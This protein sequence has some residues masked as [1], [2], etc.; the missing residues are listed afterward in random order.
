[1][2]VKFAGLDKLEMRCFIRFGI[3]SRET[4]VVKVFGGLSLQFC[5]LDTTRRS[6]TQIGD[7]I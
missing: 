1:M 6:A 2:S 3:P 4:E 7:Y 5:L